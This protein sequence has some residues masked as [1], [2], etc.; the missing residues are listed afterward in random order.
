MLEVVESSPKG[1]G[2]QAKNVAEVG[3]CT[4]PNTRS[5]R[6][7][8]GCCFK[9]KWHMKHRISPCGVGELRSRR[10]FLVAVLGHVIATLM[11]VDTF[12]PYLLQEVQELC[13]T[14]LKAEYPFIL[15]KGYPAP[16]GLRTPACL[17]LVIFCHG[18]LHHAFTYAL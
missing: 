14:I 4:E 15:G 3:S 7:A 13:S 5:T 6:S 18:A 16:W 8:G 9:A 11:T 1:R 12:L 17:A 10:S 2:S